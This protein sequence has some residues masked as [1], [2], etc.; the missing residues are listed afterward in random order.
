MKMSLDPRTRR[1]IIV[2]VLAQALIGAQMPMIFTM[3][4]LA[5]QSLASNPCLATFPISLI[6]FGSMLAANPLASIMRLYGRRVGF[7]LGIVC[8]ALGS[9]LA[10]YGLYIS[11]FTLFLCGSFI[12]GVYMSAQ[13]FYRFAAADTADVSIQPKA[14]S[15][16]MG[17]GLIAAIIGPQLI[18]WTSDLFVIPFLGSYLTI[19][20]INFVGI[21]L[22][23][24]IDIPRPQADGHP[25]L[26]PRPN[27]ELL[28]QKPNI[29]A[30]ICAM[31]SFALMSL[32]MTSAPLAVVG[33]GFGRNAAADIVSSHVL[34]MYIPSFFTGHLINRFGTTRII[35]LGLMI[36]ACAGFVSL[37]G[38]DLTHFFIT[39]VLLGIGWNFGFIGATTLLTQSHESRDKER[40]QG[41]NDFIVFGGV[42]LSSLASGGLMNC[43]GGTV[44]AGWSAVNMAMLPFLA[45]AAASLLWLRF[46]RRAH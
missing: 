2:L 19:I 45:L 46:P 7:W 21:A 13:G 38:V 43:S 6:M 23:S 17:G 34:A 26:S 10:A 5:G 24:Q 35:S 18:K 31:V 12:T 37:L 27:R 32:V 8:G 20:A 25:H 29:V 1:N 4:G 28:Q 16:V 39:M 30:M 44:L 33:C 22:I 15:Y 9:A 14:I 36:L 42:T 3:G 41:L 40:V 11:S